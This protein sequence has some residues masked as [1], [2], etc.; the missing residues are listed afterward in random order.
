VWKRNK[1]VETI[2]DIYYNFLGPHRS[3]PPLLCF[4]LLALWTS[5]SGGTLSGF[6]ISLVAWATFLP[7]GIYAI[8]LNENAVTTKRSR[9]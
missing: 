3:K 5:A 1:V 8:D 7:L 6:I 4:L 2:G 9:R